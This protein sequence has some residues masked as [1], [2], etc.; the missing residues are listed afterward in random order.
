MTHDNE[1]EFGV[2]MIFYKKTIF[3]S[4]LGD[5]SVITATN[6]RKHCFETG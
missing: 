5:Q 2:K 4:G 3:L 1:K 6:E